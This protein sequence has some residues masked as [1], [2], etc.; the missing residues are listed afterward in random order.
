MLAEAEHNSQ[1]MCREDVTSISCYTLFVA[2]REQWWNYF[3]AKKNWVSWNVTKRGVHTIRHR[4]RF[5]WMRVATENTVKNFFE[6]VK[7]PPFPAN[8]FCEKVFHETLTNLTNHTV[9]TIRVSHEF[10]SF[11]PFSSLR[12][13]CSGII[14]DRHDLWIAC[15][16]WFL[17]TQGE[18]MVYINRI[19]RDTDREDGLQDDL[20]I[21]W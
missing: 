12:I 10:R 21:R 4:S 5:S 2:V 9:H 20:T 3:F 6:F 14:N 13:V 19:L 11:V 15:G 18:A 1:C 8:A 17:S 16:C 7:K